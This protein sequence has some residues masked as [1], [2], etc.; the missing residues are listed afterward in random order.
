MPA[1]SGAG[2][3]GTGGDRGRRRGDAGACGRRDGGAA[4]AAGG[5]HQAALLDS[6][7]EPF[8]LELE[9]A[10]LVLANDVENAINLV[11]IHAYVIV[12]ERW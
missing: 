3:F 9:L 1:R 8:A 11:E 10:Q 12:Q 2:R 7:L 6:D 4:S 5:V